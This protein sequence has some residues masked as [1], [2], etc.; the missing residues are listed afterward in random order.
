MN[1]YG[2]DSEELPEYRK[3]FNH[4]R[5]EVL[6]CLSDAIYRY[7]RYEEEFGAMLLYGEEPLDSATYDEIIRQTDHIYILEKNF[8]LV[9]FDHVVPEGS[10]KAA[11]NFLHAF[12]SKDVKKRVFVAVAPIEEEDDTAIDIASRL[13][14]ILEYAVKHGLVNSVI[15][16]GQMKM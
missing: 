13:F 5:E 16:L 2:S 14:I 4:Y 11:Q 15:D 6:E 1:G 8:W 3:N 7:R 12:L 10:V 9:F